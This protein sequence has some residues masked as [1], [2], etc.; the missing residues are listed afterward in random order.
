MSN[1][2]DQQVE[3]IVQRVAPSLTHLTGPGRVA[4]V[5]RIAAATLDELRGDGKEPK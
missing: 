2:T 3:A 5:V 4:D 1:L